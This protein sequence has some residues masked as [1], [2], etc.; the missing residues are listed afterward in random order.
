MGFWLSCSNRVESLQQQLCARLLGEPLR[1]PF[2]PEVILVP[3]NAMRRWLGLQI[4]VAHG[5]AANIDFP[6]PAAWIWQLAARAHSLDPARVPSDDPLSREQAAWQIF[7]VLPALL[8]AE[9]FEELNR[10]LRDD[11]TQVKR[12]QLAQRIADVFDRYQYYRPDWIRA[13][14][15]PGTPAMPPGAPY[16]AWQPLLWR[17]LVARCGGAHRVAL[18]DQLGDEAADGD[19]QKRRHGTDADGAPALSRAQ[20]LGEVDKN[21]AFRF[22]INKIQDQNT[23][24]GASGN[25]R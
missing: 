5:V 6:L 14:S 18:L 11:T 22:K 12:W 1:D 13:W 10:Y 25:T 21:N 23:R 20:V 7:A 8:P 2:Q 17:E 3:G 4:A 15:R 24:Y 9:E 19:H 16:P